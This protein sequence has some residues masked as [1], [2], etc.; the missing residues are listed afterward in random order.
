[1]QPGPNDRNR[2]VPAPEQRL[3]DCCQGGSHT[4]LDRQTDHLEGSLPIFAAT[5]SEA[6]E[7]E[8]LR[9]F[10]P[11]S[12]SIFFGEPTEFN[13]ARFVRMQ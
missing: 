1:M 6:K 5:V 9:S 11:P 3:A 2:F 12:A 4:L 7:V 8:G 13:Q 10:L